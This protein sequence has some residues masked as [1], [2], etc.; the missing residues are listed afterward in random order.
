[1]TVLSPAER[2]V[3]RKDFGEIWNSRMIRVTM[4]IV[5]LVMAI[6]L[7]AFFLILITNIPLN[8]IN[9]VTQM[10][11]LLPEEMKYLN[12]RQSIFFLMTDIVC[13]MFFLMIPLM[14]SSVSA[15]SSFVGEKEHGTL[16]TLLLTPMSVRKIYKAKVAAC[17]SLSAVV[18]A[19]SFVAFA[20]VV[21]VGDLLLGLPFFLNWSWL[22]LIF[23]LS[24]G[25]TVF[26]IVF[27][28]LVSGKSKN[29]NESIQTSGYLVLPVILLFLGQFTG[30][31]RVGPALLLALSAVVLAVDILLLL[32]AAGLF[33][34]EKLLR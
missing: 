30:L 16:E 22:I 10:M 17:F 33:T 13:P 6:F 34:P 26:G 20:V 18:T 23:L 12:E 27:M 5:P 8:Q 19:V 31:F 7:P 21:S 32:L 2:A 29:Y 25:I 9:G 11:R 4:I 3:A 14:S 15:A 24:P 28:V 1:M